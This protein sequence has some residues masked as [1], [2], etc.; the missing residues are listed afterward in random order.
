MLKN[1]LNDIKERIHRRRHMKAVKKRLHFQKIKQQV[2]DN[3]QI[4]TA[5][6]HQSKKHER[7]SR[8]N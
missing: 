4:K 5:S 2:K 1:R 6:F 8:L 3:K 7:V